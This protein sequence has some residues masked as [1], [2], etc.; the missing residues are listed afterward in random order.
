MH[1]TCDIEYVM[2]LVPGFFFCSDI[3]SRCLNLAGHKYPGEAVAQLP[4]W[5]KEMDG[6]LWLCCLE[7]TGF[8]PFRFF[9]IYKLD[10]CFRL[11]SSL[12]L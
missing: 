11:L 2:Y 1:V 9:L 7:L 3:H 8:L 12:S 4:F 6:L 5:V 10:L